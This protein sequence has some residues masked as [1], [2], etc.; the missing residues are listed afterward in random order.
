MLIFD[1]DG[2]LM[3]SVREIAVTSYN[4]LK[5]TIV[6]RLEHLPQEALNLFFRNRFHIQ[7]IGDAPVLMKWCLEAHESDP[8]ILL[9]EKEYNNIIG[10]VDE[11]VAVRTTRFFDTRARFKAKDLKAWIALNTPVQPLWDRLIEGRGRDLVILTNKNRE[12]TLALC[13]HFGLQINNANIYSGD[14]GTTKI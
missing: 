8:Q 7:P 2:V 13:D 6:T 14:N 4:T 12:A 1:F 3:D 9:S 11:P 5:N 10:R